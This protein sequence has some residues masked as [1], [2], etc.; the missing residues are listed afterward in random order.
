[1]SDRDE[2][3]RVLNEGHSFPGPYMFKIIG[4]NSPD[5]VVRVMQAAVIVAGPRAEP[6]VSIRESSGGRH[7]AVTLSISVESAE[8][9]LDLYAAF[10][11]VAGVRFLL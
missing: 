5:F 7:Q 2:S 1:M 9:V 8:K 3:L 6:E 11:T 4:D 10:R